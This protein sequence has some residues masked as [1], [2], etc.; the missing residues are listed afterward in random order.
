GENHLIV[1]SALGNAKES[2]KLLLTKNHPVRIPALGNPLGSPQLPIKRGEVN[3][4]LVLNRIC[5]LIE[6]LPTVRKTFKNLPIIKSLTANRILLKAIP[7][8]TYTGRLEINADA[9]LLAMGLDTKKSESCSKFKSDNHLMP[10]PA[11]FEARGSFRLLL[12]KNHPVPN[13]AF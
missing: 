13:P 5:K 8:L 9:I 6:K 2:V 12:T 4:F 1:C 3:L 10:S 11:L 7:P